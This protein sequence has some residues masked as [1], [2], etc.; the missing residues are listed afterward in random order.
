M[1]HRFL[2]ALFFQKNR[3]LFEE[4]DLFYDCF[5]KYTSTINY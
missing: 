5:A 1:R 3:G 2:K 4:L